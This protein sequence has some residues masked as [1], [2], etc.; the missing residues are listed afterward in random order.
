MN[1]ADMLSYSDIAELSAIAEA[2]GCECSSH[3]KN[4]LIQSILS[5]V[6]RRDVLESRVGE[7][8]G[9]DL[10]FLNSL[11]FESRSAYSLEELKA[12]AIG[13]ESSGASTGLVVAGNTGDTAASAVTKPLAAKGKERKKKTDAVK[14]P[15]GPDETARQ[16]ISRFK[17][18]GWLFNGFSQ[19][20]RY[21]F[22]VPEDVKTRLGDALEK[23][24]RHSLDFVS[25]PP[26][27]RDEASLLAEDAGAFLKYVRD[28][29][30]PLTSDGVMYKRQLSLALE[31]MSVSETIPSRGGWRFG[32]GRKFR[33]YP[34]RFS[35]LYD[36]VYS[37]GFVAELADRLELTE[38]G[39]NAADGFAKTDQ[40]KLYRCWL[41]QYKAPVPNLTTLAQWIM[42][43]TPEWTTVDSVCR[44]L[45]PL[46]RSYYYDT[47]RDVL[48]NRV[49]RMLMHLGA[50]RWGETDKGE[51]VVKLTSQGKSL[52]SGIPPASS[53]R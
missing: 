51:A 8:T 50:L 5:T 18:N 32:Y 41:R 15:P 37:E 24:F 13:G 49:L 10:R 11:L 27:Y 36:Y 39:R 44:I 30:V 31:R 6:Q 38:Q 2:Y 12:R 4:E 21:L 33:D 7:V 29:D 19:H 17:R 42:R 14:S 9:N 40:T 43:L 3:S 23:R 34:D 1:L 20:T 46:A 25:E 48:E 28:N 47:Q 26:A 35:L 52:I 22:Q 16:S 45:Q 53:E